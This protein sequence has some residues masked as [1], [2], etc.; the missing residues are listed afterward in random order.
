MD[1]TTDPVLASH[2]HPLQ[3]ATVTVMGKAVEPYWA[4]RMRFRPLVTRDPHEAHKLVAQSK[5][6][7]GSC[8]VFWTDLRQREPEQG[9]REQQ[10][11]REQHHQQHQEE[12]GKGEQG[13]DGQT[14]VGLHQVGALGSFGCE[15]ADVVVPYV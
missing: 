2:G 11:E 14:P 4:G 15:R 9:Q 8:K 5:V 6:F 13:P 7:A 12:Q 10:A 3:Y 1:G